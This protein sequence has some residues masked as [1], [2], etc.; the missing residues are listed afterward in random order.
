MK[1]IV[2]L[3]IY[4][5]SVLPDFC[6]LIFAKFLAAIL[7]LISFRRKIIERNVTLIY[8][9]MSNQKPMIKRLYHHFAL[10]VVEM[11]RLGNLKR[12]DLQKRIDQDSNNV[13]I[14]RINQSLKHGKGVCILTGH[15]GNWEVAGCHLATAMPNTKNHIIVKSMKSVVG[16]Y[17]L[18]KI[19]DCNGVETIVKSDAVVRKVIKALRQ[20]EI[21]TFVLDQHIT[22]KVAARVDFLGQPCY[23]MT[24]LATIVH[25][26]KAPVIPVALF[27]NDDLKSYHL[28]SEDPLPFIE[29]ES[30]K[31]TITQNTQSYNYA[32]ERMLQTAP[33]QW[34][35][36]HNRWR[37]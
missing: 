28:Y 17:I 15:L 1:P 31:E 23:T 5:F 20:N 19:R 16:R 13:F 10:I 24:S 12:F 36:M 33:D 18:Y 6:S 30:T 37:S 35:W 7:Q 11:I 4:T 3:L 26:M 9:K 27:R 22:P 8:P 29:A 25:K 32:L 34:I 2:N 14:D 21:V